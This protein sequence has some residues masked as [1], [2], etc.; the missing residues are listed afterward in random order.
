MGSRTYMS[1][2]LPEEGA[3]LNTFESMVKTDRNSALR[4]HIR[5]MIVNASKANKDPELVG[6]KMP[7]RSELITSLFGLLD[8][9]ANKHLNLEELR[10]IFDWH[11][12][13][14]SDDEWSRV[15]E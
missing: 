10:I 11:G 12:F 13:N 9:D 5:E 14:G 8:S 6:K 4:E 1:L 7:G 2:G 15:Y 3:D